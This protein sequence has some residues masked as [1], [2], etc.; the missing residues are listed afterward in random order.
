MEIVADGRAAIRA[1]GLDQWQGGYPHRG[2]I[3]SDVARGESYLVEDEGVVVATAMVG[4]SGERDYDCIRE[5][6]WLTSCTSDDPCYGVVHRVSTAAESRG[7]GAAVF[8]MAGAEGLARERGADVSFDGSVVSGGAASV[9]VD[10]HP[11]N[12]PMQ[13]LLG[14]CGYVRCGI[15]LIG[16]AEGATPERVAF[17][18]LV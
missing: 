4:F 13:R 11:G 16:H 9:R 3:E 6:A 5:G 15:I 10:T 12:V 14:R 2:V 17:E 8:A 7:R 18:K 1:L